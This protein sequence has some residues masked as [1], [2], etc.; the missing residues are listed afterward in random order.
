MPRKTRTQRSVR[1]EAPATPAPSSPG[2][3]AKPP[4]V[5]YSHIRRDSS[6]GA[7]QGRIADALQGFGKSVHQVAVDSFKRDVNNRRLRGQADALKSG[8]PQGWMEA[9]Q[10]ILADPERGEYYWKSFSKQSAALAASQKS[11]SL[12]DT[13]AG[14]ETI[15]T[16]AGFNEWWQTQT[17]E[18]I[19]AI[20]DLDD[21]EASI[22][23]LT[24]LETAEMKLRSVA[25][26]READNL[27]METETNYNMTLTSDLE[28][29]MDSDG[30]HSKEGME[31][32]MVQARETGS[33]VGLSNADI[34]EGII[35]TLGERAETTG[36]PSLLN[37]FDYPHADGTPGL[38]HTK[39]GG[40]LIRTYKSAAVKEQDA[41]LAEARTERGL[42]IRKGIDNL[43]REGKPEIALQWV[44]DLQADGLATTSEVLSMRNKIMKVDEA[45][46]RKAMNVNKILAND[47]LSIEP[48]HRGEALTGYK[49]RLFKKAHGTGNPEALHEARVKVA[50]AGGQLGQME[51]ADAA[52]LKTLNI[53]DPEA[54]FE[55][56]AL[57]N[58]Y[59]AHAPALLSSMPDATRDIYEMAQ[60]MSEARIRQDQIM[61]NLQELMT[62]ES[63]ARLRA[64][65]ADKDVQAE[66]RANAAAIEAR[67]GFWNDVEI[68][69]LTTADSDIEWVRNRATEYSA[70]TGRPIEEGFAVA[71]EQ[72]GQAFGIIDLPDGG[73]KSYFKADGMPG[74]IEDMV[75]WGSDDITKEFIAEGRA[76]EGEYFMLE[77][78]P[79]TR[80]QAEKRFLVRDKNGQLQTE[81]RGG[82]TLPMTISVG[83]L[84][85][86]Y[87][88]S[89]TSE[90]NEKQ[91]ENQKAREAGY[92]D[93]Y[94]PLVDERPDDFMP[95]YVD[96][97]S[98]EV[99]TALPDEIPMVG[100]PELP[101]AEAPQGPGPATRKAPKRPPV[102]SKSTELVMKFEGFR[103]EPYYA[104]K[105][106]KAKGIQTV[107]YGR[108]TGVIA[109][110]KVN[111]ADERKWLESQLQDTEDA[112]ASKVG[113]QW[114][115]LSTNQKAAVVSLAYNVD[116]DV[117][118][119]LLTSR[120]LEALK[121]GDWEK[122][123]YE[124]FDADAGFTKQEGETL[125]GL[126]K[127]RN[128]E[129]A[130]F[131]SIE[132]AQ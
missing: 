39:V 28:M 122:F 116:K 18:D 90:T 33:A 114:N 52:K 121:A 24:R 2:I 17:Q 115:K 80:S 76:K 62:P 82:L 99:S 58:T 21:P 56:V 128:E 20:Q 47:T 88:D 100:S 87:N 41:Q 3:L 89:M 1:Q 101:G 97:G 113:P 124:A 9:R 15:N 38:A 19:K 68:E 92:N 119:Q 23:Y 64:L 74:N 60:R 117:V 63:Q 54:M 77:P 4:F 94:R 79:A 12:S 69:N 123:K 36:D 40:A 85:R 43:I 102:L 5:Q 26:K 16:T 125:D 107:G 37:I 130:I 72:W 34:N 14:D 78:D 120:A 51:P 30:S 73:Q 127:R 75:Q 11:A 105:K 104:T 49:E 46:A 50:Q 111:E 108:T 109:G 98:E 65:R 129:R 10:E 66:L 118:G 84:K 6:K 59:R 25:A 106:E 86:D 71:E 32:W 55:Q 8:A 81:V 42:E 126:V 131:E 27:Y 29:W 13:I 7:A 22:A 35:R 44:D 70:R 93:P 48:K 57:Y 103:D 61:V 45:G 132:E 112:L 95:P 110:Q 96:P 31:A 83:E 67:T 53:Q 91:A